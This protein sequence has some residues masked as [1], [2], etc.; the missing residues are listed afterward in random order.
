MVMSTV[1]PN[2]PS[3]ADT[4]F[5]F[6]TGTVRPSS[7]RSN[8]NSRGRS[9]RLYLASMRSTVSGPH[10]ISDTSLSKRSRTE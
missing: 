4:A 9:V 5:C 6:L 10:S 7:E 1:L 2:L 3:M 8:V